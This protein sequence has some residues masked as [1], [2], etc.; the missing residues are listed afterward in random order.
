M[1]FSTALMACVAGLA[2]AS[3]HMIMKTPTP[4][5]AA[6]INNSPLDASGSDYPCMYIL[7]PYSSSLY[8]YLT[9][10]SCSTSQDKSKKITK[11][12]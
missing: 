5:G 4:Y 2:P 7:E 12:C 1:H 9:R 6:T 3:A 8:T 11:P 10:N